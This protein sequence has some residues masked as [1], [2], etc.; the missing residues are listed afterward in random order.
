[1]RFI[2]LSTLKKITTELGD[3]TETTV[4]E[5]LLD[6]LNANPGLIENKTYSFSEV[7]AIL[8]VIN[9]RTVVFFQWIEQDKG[10]LQILEG[11]SPT[12]TFKDHFHWIGHALSTDFS[13]FLA[14]FLGPAALT[15]NGEKNTATL[16]NLFSYLKLL[17]ADD[18][19][20]VEQ[21]LFKSIR[22]RVDIELNNAGS[23]TSEDGLLQLTE[24]VCS[25]EIMTII[26]HLSR[27]SYHTKVWYVDEILTL[28]KHPKCSA[29]LAYRIIQRLKE[30]E[31]N[32]EHKATISEIEKELKTGQI[33]ADK[34]N[35]PTNFNVR[36]K[37]ILGVLFFFGLILSVYLIV[38]HEEKVE[39]NPDL[40][41]ASSFE[42]FNKEERQQIDS[43]LRSQRKDS[44]FNENEQDQYLWAQGSGVSLT[45][46]KPLQNERMEELY[47]DWLLDAQLFE[48]GIMDSCHSGNSKKTY[49]FKDVRSTDQLKG[50]ETT[51]IRNETDYAV[52]IFVFDEKKGGNVYSVLLKKN[53]T[54][55]LDLETGQHLLFIP[56]N[57]LTDFKKPSGVGIGELPSKNFDHHF[58]EVDYNLSISLNTIYQLKFPQKGSNK[59]LLSG[60]ELSSFVVADLY[61]ILETL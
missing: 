16:S 31:L 47:N 43:L 22:D 11:K 23:I 54:L 57:T 33:L 29:R 1:M 48:K 49:Q 4:R 27:S 50:N 2:S 26:G 61:G 53:K 56:G 12:Q 41:L 36:L 7:Q 19:L 34:K 17:P 24:S 30:L 59:L 3:P 13:T 60:D 6:E 15:F 37:Q 35:T 44:D 5:N 25:A 55:S 21:E 9:E 45:L 8:S 32:P 10:L 42:Q 18:Q 20:V 51:A 46:R 40:N 39:T 38:T 58:C 14:P 28:F 52:Y